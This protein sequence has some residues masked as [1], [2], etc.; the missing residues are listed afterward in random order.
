[1]FEQNPHASSSQLY[2]GQCAL[3]HLT[4]PLCS[5]P[6]PKFSQLDLIANKLESRQRAVDH[7]VMLLPL[8]CA[9]ATWNKLCNNVPYVILMDLLK[10]VRNFQFCIMSSLMQ[11]L[12]KEVLT[13]QNVLAVII[14][15]EC[16]PSIH[17][18]LPRM[19]LLG[20]KRL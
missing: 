8:V 7:S 14:E 3:V 13:A 4:D 16:G 17:L 15:A 18:L 2:Y 20:L 12:P 6:A 9:R 19:G 11:S 10:F 1:M 5:I